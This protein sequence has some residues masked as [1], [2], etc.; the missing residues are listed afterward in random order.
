VSLKNGDLKLFG[1]GGLLVGY[2]SQGYSPEL[3]TLS[4]LKKERKML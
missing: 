1:T 2:N 3:S 4:E